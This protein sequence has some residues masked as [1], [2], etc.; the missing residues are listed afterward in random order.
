MS[1]W[2]CLDDNRRYRSFP[3]SQC[4]APSC[5]MGKKPKPV[6]RIPLGPGQKPCNYCSTPFRANGRT[7][8][9]SETCRYKA[10]MQRRKARRVA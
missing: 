7:R 9:C 3:C 4:K 6:A 5:W 2:P 10:M 8:Y 1:V